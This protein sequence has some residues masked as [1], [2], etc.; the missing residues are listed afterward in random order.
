[1]DPSRV[2]ASS[3]VP[4]DGAPRPEAAWRR[5]RWSAVAVRVATVAIPILVAVAA[6]AAVHASLHAT[7][8]AGQAGVWAL[9]V[10]A[11]AASFM[12]LDA[13]CR[14]LLPLSLLLELSL[15]FPD[16]APSRLRVALR[17][18]STK[19]LLRAQVLAAGTDGRRQTDGEGAAT[20]LALAASL[21][22]HDRAT[23]GHCERVRAY[24]ELIADQL[25][26]GPE[27]H[28]KLRW[29][30][31][32]HDV[33]KISVPTDTLNATHPLSDVE[34]DAIRRHPEEGARLTVPVS[35]WLGPWAHAIEQ[36]HERFDGR[37]YPKGLQGEELT[38]GARIVAVADSYDAMTT[39]RSYNKPM[40]PA[41]ARQQLAAKAGTQ[42]DPAVVRAFLNIGLGRLRWVVG[43]IAAFAVVPGLAALRPL[44]QR[45]RQPISVAA[46]T[47]SVAAAG[48][49]PTGGKLADPHH[50]S[51]PSP[52]EVASSSPAPE[53]TAPATTTALADAIPPGVGDRGR[54]SGASLSTTARG[55]GPAAGTDDGRGSRPAPPPPPAPLCQIV[56]PGTACA[57]VA[58]DRR[59]GPSGPALTFTA[60]AAV[61]GVGDVT[62]SQPA[63]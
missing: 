1:M 12:L 32:L 9:V 17:A 26:L 49:V 34:W 55:L 29:A 41:A 48:L 52:G 33:G 27:D 28:D 53:A 31:L 23:R 58:V 42:F 47:L 22:A 43:P 3:P 54:S 38:L 50:A 4:V 63:G 18:G 10:G 14:R 60:H 8:P 51:R 61:D 62:V 11:A 36:H 59:D 30:S 56:V 39:K 7:T 6:T 21:S 45:A 19:R 37:G 20:V 24:A 40:A 16:H 57:G 44:L 5:H 25:G 13:A 35:A 46:A 2:G 15:A